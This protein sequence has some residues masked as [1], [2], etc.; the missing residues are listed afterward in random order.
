MTTVYC[1]IEKAKDAAFARQAIGAL[2]TAFGVAPVN[3]AVLRRAMR[4]AGR[5][6]RTGCAPPRR[7]R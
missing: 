1:V 5:I 6:S 7:R 4:L 2:L 3:E